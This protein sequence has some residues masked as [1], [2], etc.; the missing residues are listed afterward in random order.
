M[1]PN[2]QI[3]TMKNLLLFA[4]LLAFPLTA[5]AHSHPVGYTKD[6]KKVVAF[7]KFGGRKGSR[8]VLR[9]FLITIPAVPHPYNP[10]ILKKKDGYLLAF[11]NDCEKVTERVRTGRVGLIKLDR[12]FKPMTA[13]SKILDTECSSAEDPRL[14][15]IGGKA[16]VVYTKVTQ[17]FPV[18]LGNIGI[19]Q[20][21]PK[22]GVS[23]IS[24][25]ML[26][27]KGTMEKNWTPFVYSNPSVPQ[28]EAFV[29][30]SYVP[31]MIFKVKYPLSG[32][33]SMAYENG[34]A[35][36]LKKWQRKWGEIRGGT[37]AVKTAHGDYIT[38]FHS[39]FMYKK[40]RYYV[41]GA[42]VF[43]G[44]PPFRIKKISKKPILFKGIYSSPVTKDVWFY[45]RSY[46]RVLF[47]GGLVKGEE[48]GR[49]VF[50][51]ICG[52]NDVAI[53]NVVIDQKRLFKSLIDVHY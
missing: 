39:S 20:F 52:E 43:E 25:D 30:Y 35:R 6:I 3:R 23:E 27:R 53:R 31:H 19:T 1:L 2:L 9:S 18:T 36:E 42:L 34:K 24:K 8:I 47:P 14:F 12:S 11:R 28:E 15:T 33:V 49:K 48:K 32:E 45:P 26:Y 29:I 7:K 41:M 38:F 21:N 50:Y 4:A 13:T 22:T 40:L 16:C 44:K 51:V 5:F 10:S 46:L 37:P 17:F